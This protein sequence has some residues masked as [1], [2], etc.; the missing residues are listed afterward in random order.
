MVRE[1][2]SRSADY[3]YT[4]GVFLV[5]AGTEHVRS[6]PP[7]SGAAV[8]A[9]APIVGPDIHVNLHQISRLR[10]GLAQCPPAGHSDVTVDVFIAP[11]SQA[12]GLDVGRELDVVLHGEDGHVVPL[13]T[14][15]SVF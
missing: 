6:D 5:V 1:K 15:L 3:T 4:A 13:N 2:C 12:D 10:P 8:A 7:G 14:M 11:R 9:V